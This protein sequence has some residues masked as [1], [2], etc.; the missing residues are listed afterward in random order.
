MN[1]DKWIEKDK[2]LADR[3]RSATLVTYL[4]LKNPE[5]M[6]KYPNAQIGQQIFDEKPLYWKIGIKRPPTLEQRHAQIAAQFRRDLEAEMDLGQTEELL[7]EE[8]PVHP[9]ETFYEKQGA[10]FDAVPEEIERVK[11]S[12]TPPITPAIESPKE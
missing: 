1:P 11:T 7:D 3:P 8:Y 2:K 10:I 9:L 12:V 5:F 4:N 6:K